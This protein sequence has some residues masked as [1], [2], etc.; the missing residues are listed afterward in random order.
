MTPDLVWR[1][2]FQILK[3]NCSS[4]YYKFSDYWVCPFEKCTVKIKKNQEVRT[5]FN[6]AMASRWNLKSLWNSFANIDGLKQGCIW[7]FN[8]SMI[9]SRGVVK[10][11][12]STLMEGKRFC[13]SF[14]RLFILLKLP[15]MLCGKVYELVKLL[16]NITFFHLSLTG[17]EGMSSESEEVN[18][19]F[20]DCLFFNSV[21]YLETA[22][23]I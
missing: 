15:L 12:F 2:N 11:H 9:S 1:Q 5:L 20:L 16:F 13:K 23:L 8:C 7:S 19:G 21:E 18:R 22:S 14:K 17:N 10:F 3:T 6:I 4:S